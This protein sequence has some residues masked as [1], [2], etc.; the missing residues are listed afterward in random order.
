DSDFSPTLL[1]GRSRQ[2]GN[3]GAVQD[4][5]SFIA[6]NSSNWLRVRPSRSEWLEPISPLS[7]RLGL[8]TDRPRVRH[9]WFLDAPLPE[10][11]LS[12]P[13]RQDVARIS[14]RDRKTPSACT[15]RRSRFPRIQCASAAHLLAGHF[16]S[17]SICNL[18]RSRDVP[19][20]QRS[21]PLGG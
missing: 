12:G 19:R 13:G 3:A 20:I 14:H 21:I 10:E 4:T 5:Y 15:A 7:G 8:G 2:F 11:P 16:C 9:L 18:D 17:S 1:L 6:I